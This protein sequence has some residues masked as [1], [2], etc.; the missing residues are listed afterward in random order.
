LSLRHLDTSGTA[1]FLSL[2][3][4]W[5]VEFTSMSSVQKP[6][7]IPQ[8]PAICLRYAPSSMSRDHIL[9]LEFVGWFFFG[10]SWLILCSCFELESLNHPS[11]IF[12][13]SIT[14]VWPL[15]GPFNRGIWRPIQNKGQWVPDQHGQHGQHGG[16]GQC[17]PETNHS[18]RAVCWS[19]LIP[20]PAAGAILS[21]P[22]RSG[23][24]AC[25]WNFSCQ[26]T[27]S[28]LALDVRKPTGWGFNP[29]KKKL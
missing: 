27:Y 5:R 9:E 14:Q 21:S 24:I 17:F 16:K 8:L 29:H 2:M 19:I 28:P 1:C 11:R 13:T 25:W 20:D 22:D 3:A 6:W 4:I 15:S 26:E 10:L 23:T 7:Q 18:E 12:I